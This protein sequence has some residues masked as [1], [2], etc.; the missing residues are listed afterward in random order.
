VLDVQA[1]RCVYLE[2]QLPCFAARFRPLGSMKFGDNVVKYLARSRPGLADALQE[3]PAWKAARNADQ[4]LNMLPAGQSAFKKNGKGGL[5]ARVQHYRIA[6]V[7]AIVLHACLGQQ[8]QPP[9]M[10]LLAADGC[11]VPWDFSV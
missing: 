11:V 7:E 6:M 10:R 3:H 5:V 1:V 9:W 4:L 8:C 2:V